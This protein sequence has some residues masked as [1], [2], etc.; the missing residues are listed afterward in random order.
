[1]WKTRKQMYPNENKGEGRW[2]DHRYNQTER[3][4]RQNRVII[5]MVMQKQIAYLRVPVRPVPLRG[6]PLMVRLAEVG[7]GGGLFPAEKLNWGTFAG[8]L[9]N[10]EVACW[11]DSNAK[12][13][14]T[15]DRTV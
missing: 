7:V 14:C 4:R 10:P 5:Y 3:L 13:V 15:G 8:A 9:V 11:G 1:M 2:L 6:R 12:A